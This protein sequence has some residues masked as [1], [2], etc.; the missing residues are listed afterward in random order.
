MNKHQNMSNNVRIATL[1]VGGLFCNVP[2]VDQCLIK[3]C[4]PPGGI[5]RAQRNF[6][7]FVSSQAG[8]IE[9]R[10]RKIALCAENSA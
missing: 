9:K 8:L 3:G 6:S 4:F 2:Y 7:L 1:N 10:Q 5:F